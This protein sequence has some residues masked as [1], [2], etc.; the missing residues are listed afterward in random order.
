MSG[1]G[2]EEQ[3]SGARCRVSGAEKRVLG[4]GCQV[5]EKGTRR[6][7]EGGDGRGARS[8]IEDAKFQSPKCERGLP[9]ENHQSAIPNQNNPG[10]DRLSHAVARAVPWALEGLTT[11]FGMGTGVAPPVW[12]PENLSVP[13]G[14]T[15]SQI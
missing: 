10:D 13:R 15:E 11:V 7:Q 6:K 5:S 4:V 1:V 3:E 14:G 9:I 12:P 8:K 2:G